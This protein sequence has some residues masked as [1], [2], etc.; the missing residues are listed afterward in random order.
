MGLDFAV[1]WN[2][3]KINPKLRGNAFSPLLRS[4]CVDRDHLDNVRVHRHCG[5]GKTP[6]KLAVPV[7]TQSIPG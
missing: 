7:A 1:S 3:S 6:L 5:L 2:K 4:R